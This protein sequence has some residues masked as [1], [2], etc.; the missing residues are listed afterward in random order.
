MSGGT[1]TGVAFFLVATGGLPF[2][3]TSPG[4]RGRIQMTRSE[5]LILARRLEQLE[6]ELKKIEHEI[7]EVRRLLRR[8][9]GHEYSRRRDRTCSRSVPLT[10]QR[11]TLRNRQRKTR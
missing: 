9:L 3:F 8:K 6:I 7:S 11:G 2:V 1:G 5:R 4:S 10:P